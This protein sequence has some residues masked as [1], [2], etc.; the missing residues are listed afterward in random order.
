MATFVVTDPQSGLKL[1]LTGDSPPTEQEL[2]AIFAAQIGQQVAGEQSGAVN[3]GSIPSVSGDGSGELLDR[4]QEQ[5][6]TAL[7]VAEPAAT[8]ASTIVAEPIAGVAGIAS[9]AGR[10]AP[11]PT[12]IAGLGGLVKAG[13]EAFDVELPSGVE[14]IESVREALTFQPR[15]EAGQAGLEAVGETLEP[16]GE[17]LT[18]AESFLGDAVLE[19][20]DSPAL[21]AAASTLPTA[22]LEII[23]LKGGGR[24]GRATKRVGPS[25]KEVSTAIVESAPEVRTLKKRI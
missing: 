1:R 25:A 23:G 17:A 18:S 15:T 14:A 11:I 7:G 8:I 3:S 2:E 13:L 4:Q 24:L 5:G 19:A 10:R 21:A 12:P 6:L 16:I 22:A 20:T 9:E